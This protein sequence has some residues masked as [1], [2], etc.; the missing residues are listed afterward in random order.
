[1]RKMAKFSEYTVSFYLNFSTM[2]LSLLCL[3]IVDGKHM[4]DVLPYFNWQSWVL[5]TLAGV[6]CI[7]QQVLRFKA[8]R[9]QKASVL[10]K[11][12][13]LITLWQFFAD[14]ALFGVRYSA[15]T[16]SGFALL[17]S[18]Y[19]VQILYFFC[20]E[21]KREEEQKRKRKEKE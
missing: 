18:A 12:T 15:L 2:M 8:L 4:F 14:L 1:M 6:C 19:I 3:G 16:Y 11:Y 7:I 13:P 5:I 10:Q 17:F 9:Y 21:K 20:Y